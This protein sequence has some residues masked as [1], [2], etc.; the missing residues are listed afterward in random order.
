M[1]RNPGEAARRSADGSS[2]FHGHYRG[3]LR[4]FLDKDIAHVDDPP[5]LERH[6]QGCAA[7]ASGQHAFVDTVCTPH[8]GQNL[9]QRRRF[10]VIARCCH[11]R[12]DHV[13]V[14]VA[15][16]NDFV[17]FQLLVPAEADVVAALFGGRRRAIAMNDRGIEE[18][19]LLKLRHRASENGIHAAISLPPA[20]GAV[21]R[22]W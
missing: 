13:A 19:I 4:D 9:P 17:A 6:H 3:T 7:G 5:R 12:C 18:V 10:A 16:G 22:V 21:M 15:E 2:L 1:S 14:A 8:L 11:E 20:Q